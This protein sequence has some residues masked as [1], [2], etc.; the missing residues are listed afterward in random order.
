M[1]KN[2]INGKKLQFGNVEQIKYLKQFEN[3]FIPIKNPVHTKQT[4]TIFYLKFWF[5]CLNCNYKNGETLE[6]DDND[7]N[8]CYVICFNCDTEYKLMEEKL[9]IT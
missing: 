5:E 9:I 3:G 7:F 6:S 1:S 2:R 4:K 8:G